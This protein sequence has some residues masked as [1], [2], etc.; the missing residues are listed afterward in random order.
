M[1]WLA[2]I[3]IAPSV[4]KSALSPVVQARGTIKWSPFGVSRQSLEGVFS[5]VRSHAVE[6]SNIV[7][8]TVQI[9]RPSSLPA[10][11]RFE[12][13]NIRE[14]VYEMLQRLAVRVPRHADRKRRL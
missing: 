8:R 5:E 9:H 14:C 13:R 1:G 6:V 10:N 4:E 3:L 2:R 11:L 12:G 7:L